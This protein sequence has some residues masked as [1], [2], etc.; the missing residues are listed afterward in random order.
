MTTVRQ[1]CWYWLPVGAYATLIFYVSSLSYP[2][3]YVPSVLMELGDKALHAIEYAVLGILCYRA[4][5]RAA[6]RWAA[7]HA[8]LL[9]IVA[10]TGYGLTDEIHQAAVPLRQADVWDFATD[11]IGATLGC[12]V[13]HW[14]ADPQ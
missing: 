10:S 8:V 5:R 12:S 7:S 13:W 2:E 14:L 1:A 11:A 6:G 3:V 4:F 9:A